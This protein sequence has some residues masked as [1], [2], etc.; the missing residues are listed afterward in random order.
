[1]NISNL[2]KFCG[3]VGELAPFPDSKEDVLEKF[4]PFHFLIQMRQSIGPLVEIWLVNTILVPSPALV[5]MVFISL[6][7]RFWASSQIK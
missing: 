2:Q 7:V 3:N 5:M 1:M 4:L 6:G